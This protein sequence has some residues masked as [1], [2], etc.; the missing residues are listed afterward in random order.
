MEI[1]EK[2]NCAVQKHFHR[3]SLSER[4]GDRYAPLI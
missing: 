1:G 2:I 4:L 3:L